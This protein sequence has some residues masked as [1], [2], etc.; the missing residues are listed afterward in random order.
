MAEGCIRKVSIPVLKAMIESSMAHFLDS[1]VL[2]KEG[3]GY[4]ENLETMM[5]ILIHGITLTTKG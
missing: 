1:E 2:Q 5:D 3:N 4:T